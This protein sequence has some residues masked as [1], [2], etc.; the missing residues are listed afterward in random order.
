M[1]PAPYAYSPMNLISSAAEGAT[2]QV[3]HLKRFYSLDC[4]K[5]RSNE[6]CYFRK[7]FSISGKSVRNGGLVVGKP[8]LRGD[9]VE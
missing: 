9:G 5:I 3:V 7:S 4:W 8:M 6:V 2:P 1:P